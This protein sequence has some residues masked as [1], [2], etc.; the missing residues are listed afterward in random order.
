MLCDKQWLI[1]GNGKQVHFILVHKM[2]FCCI[3]I[4]FS[5]SFIPSHNLDG[6]MF[7]ALKQ[8]LAPPHA[9]CKW[10]WRKEEAPAIASIS[11]S[12]HQTACLLEK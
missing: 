5:H 2:S 8:T 11:T 10:N 3:L 1:V 4:V 6:V 7:K 9:S 12:K